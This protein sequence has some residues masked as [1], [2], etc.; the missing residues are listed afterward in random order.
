MG[1]AG[2]AGPHHA[3]GPR[4]SGGGPAAR[5]LAGGIVAGGHAASLAHHLLLL[6]P[7]GPSWL[8]LGL[9]GPLPLT[10][11][12]LL[13]RDYP[14]PQGCNPKNDKDGNPVHWGAV[15]YKDLFGPEGWCNAD[16]SKFQ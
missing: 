15:D 12:L 6:A 9:L 8:Q 3:G 5:W 4:A 13:N 14:L 7:A 1:A 16:M 11:R 2:E 10:P